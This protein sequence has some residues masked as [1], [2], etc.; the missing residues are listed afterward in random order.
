MAQ[1]SNQ[2][3]A[4]VIERPFARALR[5]KISPVTTQAQ[6]PHEQAKKKMYTQTKA[7][8]TLFETWDEGSAVPTLATIN[9]QTDMPIAPNKSNGRRPHFSTKYRPGKVEQTLTM[10]VIYHVEH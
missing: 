1:L 10:L 9:W 5:G 3:E 8:R 6:G 4:V 7:M 2:L